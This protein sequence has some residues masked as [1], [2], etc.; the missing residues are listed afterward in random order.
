[1]KRH[2]RKGIM[3]LTLALTLGGLT[4]CSSFFNGSEYTISDVTSKTDIDGNTI[5]TI[6]FNESG[7]DP[8][9][10]TIP[11]GMSGKDGVSIKNVVS[12][13]K[14]N[15]VTLTI[16]YTDASIS[17]TVISIPVIQGEAGKG[18]TNVDI[19]EDEF[20]NKVV[21]FAYNDGTFSDSITIPKGQDGV[22]I[23]DISTKA[24][25][26]GTYTEITITFSDPDKKPVT[27]TVG[28]GRGVKSVIFSQEKSTIT[29]YALVIT[30]T[31]DYT[32]TI[33]I[34]KPVATTWHTGTVSPDKNDSLSNAV[35]GDFYLNVSSGYVYQLNAKGVWDILFSMKG[36]SSTEQEKYYTVSFDPGEGIWPDATSKYKVVMKN[37]CIDLV[38]IKKPT[39]EGFKFS[40]WYTTLVEDV[41]AGHFTDLTPV[42]KDMTL[43]AHYSSL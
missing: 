2:L 36:D 25:S 24:S 42:T 17:P 33:M 31:D 13:I 15:V 18:I 22:G 4:S 14:D 28:N 8:L 29:Q 6:T 37:T 5:V 10:F 7:K 20:G 30:Y 32:E 9:T 19:S 21:I 12:S 41:N 43:Y 3:F 23:N 26:D 27:F 40:G 35:T 1:M 38:D 16:V 11:K 39:K 34:D